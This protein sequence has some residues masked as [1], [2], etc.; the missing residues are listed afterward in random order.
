MEYVIPSSALALLSR[1]REAGYEAY[2]VGGCV[3][4]LLRGEVP[5]DYDMTTSATPSEMKAV[6]SRDRVIETGIKHGTLTV[7]SD[8]VPYEITTYR[9]DGTYTDSRHPDAVR[10]TRSLSLDLARRD[11]TVN[12]MAYAP[13][14]GIVD[15]FGGRDDLDA[16]ILRAVGDPIRRFEEDALRILRALRFSSVLGYEIEKETASAARALAD[17]L[18]LVSPERVR[19]ELSKLLCGGS[20]KAVMC[21][22]R[23]V[24]AA[25]VPAFRSLGENGQ[26]AIDLATKLPSDALSLRLAALFS[27]LGA[28]GARDALRALRF[29]NKT[30][31]R[32]LRVLPHLS[33]PLPQSDAA[34]LKLLSVLDEEGARDRLAVARPSSPKEV[35]A[36][37]RRLEAL[38]AEGRCYRIRDLQVNGEILMQNGFQKGKEIGKTL[39][40][41]LEKVISGELANDRSLL[42]RDA[43]QRRK[44]GTD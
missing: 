24:L 9:V 3:R 14:E 1:L 19:V 20:A 13:G 5:A 43:I 41:L 37:L 17:R 8:G 35:D 26:A 4:D 33:E 32:V 2:L 15:P 40:Y 25:A 21:E 44:A 28:D 42:L 22:Y 31:D 23:E 18:S 30:I 27:P 10:F 38:V 16:K 12:A 34:L 11:F 6:F 36:L 39:S 7:L 29:D